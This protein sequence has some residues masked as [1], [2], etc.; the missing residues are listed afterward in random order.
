MSF[1]GSNLHCDARTGWGWVFSVCKDTAQKWRKVTYGDLWRFGATYGDLEW[2]KMKNTPCPRITSGALTQGPSPNPSTRE[3][4]IIYCLM[5]ALVSC[6]YSL[7]LWEGW[8]GVRT[9][10]SKKNFTSLF[11]PCW[12]ENPRIVKARSSHGISREHE[13]TGAWQYVSIS[14]AMWERKSERKYIRV[15][16]VVY[17]NNHLNINLMYSRSLAHLFSKQCGCR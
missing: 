12:A 6:N 1:E 9:P 13:W 16:G 4:S 14:H 8:G 15:Q 2:N 7:P 17:Q 10:Y 3:G 11:P 5:W